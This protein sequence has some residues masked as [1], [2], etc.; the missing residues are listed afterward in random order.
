VENLSEIATHKKNGK[1]LMET[2]FSGTVPG[3]DAKKNRKA[4]FPV[5]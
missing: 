3:T 2:Y 1:I 5:W 4:N